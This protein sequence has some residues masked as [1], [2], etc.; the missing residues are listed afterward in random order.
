VLTLKGVKMVPE[1]VF[2]ERRK[3][4]SHPVHIATVARMFDLHPQR[5]AYWH[6]NYLSD[7]NP[8]IS[9]GKWPAASIATEP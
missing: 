3:I 9:S 5:L 4:E 1:P 7:C 2:F 6:Q 8:D